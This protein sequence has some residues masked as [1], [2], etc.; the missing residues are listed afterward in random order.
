MVKCGLSNSIWVPRFFLP[1]PGKHLRAVTEGIHRFDVDHGGCGRNVLELHDAPN[2]A[3]SLWC[4][5][6]IDL[7]SL[8]ASVL[9]EAEKKWAAWN[10]IAMGLKWSPYQA[11]KSMNFAEEVIQG[12]HEDAENVVKWN[13]VRLNLPGAEGYNPSLP[14][15]FKV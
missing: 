11:V 14:W 15:V 6:C 4:G 9:E 3:S 12:N 8:G 5:P 1:T 13:Y 2:V 7:T 10:Q